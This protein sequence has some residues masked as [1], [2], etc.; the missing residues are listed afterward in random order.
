MENL[1]LL[2]DLYQ[3]TMLYGYHQSGTGRKRAVFTMFYRDAPGLHYAVMAGNEQ[4]REYVLNLA[5]TE[6]DIAYLRSLR[7]FGEP[8]LES[9]RAF[10]FTGDVRAVPEG[11]I[12]FPGEPLVRVDAPLEEAQLVETALLN[13]VGH[14]TLVATKANRVVRAAGGDRVLE[15]GLRRAQGPDAG[16]F[17]S[18]AAYIGGCG[19]T[20][21]VKAGQ[22]FGIPVAGTHAHSWV[23]SFDSELEAFRAYAR[24]FPDSCLLLV[25]TYDTLGSG[26]PN[27]ITVFKELKEQG[28]RPLGIRLDSGDLAYLSIRARAMLDAAGLEEAVI[29][30][31]NDLDEFLIRDLKQQG[32]K[33]SVWGVGT[34]LI[35]GMDRPSLGG[36]YKMSALE[37][38]GVMEPK[39]KLSDNPA[40]VTLPGA[41]EL[42]RIYTPDGKAAADLIALADEEVRE[43]V[44]LTLFDPQDTW[45]RMTLTEFTAKRLLQPLVIGGKA[46]GPSPTLTDIRARRAREEASVWEQHL[47]L[48]NPSVFKVDWTQR[49]WDLRRDMLHGIREGAGPAP[50]GQA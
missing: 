37:R 10:R 7:L 40:K 17:G 49:L 14:Q 41:Q 32:A 9:L 48:V 27:A 4:F 23:M 21:N 8:F 24:C 28:H 11:T 16:V 42:Y 46:A 38:D 18:R 33:I 22:V 5:F 36:V 45:K 2:T 29:T 47:R 35:T 30:A 25:D 13:I 26:V 12:V 50:G 31:S 43:D 6:A 15:F 39:I 34:R 3:L 1:T 19:F 20:S 44:P